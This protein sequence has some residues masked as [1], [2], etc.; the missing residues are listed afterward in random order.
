MANIWE[1][2]KAGDVGEVERL[3]GQ[4]PGVLNVT[5]DGGCTPLMRACEGGHV[6]VVRWLLDKG[7]ATNERGPD[8][9]TA[10]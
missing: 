4:D 1:A 5:D 7:A 6:E 2:A 9:C 8:Q 10:L 3:L